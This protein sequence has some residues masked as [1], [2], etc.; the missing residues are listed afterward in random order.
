MPTT[1]MP[2]TISAPKI[3]ASRKQYRTCH[4]HLPDSPQKFPAIAF[5]GEYYGFFKAVPSRQKTLRVAECLQQKGEAIVITQTPKGYVLWAL[6]PDAYQKPSHQ[7]PT[8][9]I[10]VPDLEGLIDAIF[11]D[12]RYYSLFQEA[13]DSAQHDRIITILESR[14]DRS[15]TTQTKTG[16]AV[17]VWEPEAKLVSFS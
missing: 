3:L 9:K 2:P 5:E 6:E 16:Y 13:P 15:I 12:N 4:I 8:C 17:W 7:Y 11:A 14:G 10:R 1:A